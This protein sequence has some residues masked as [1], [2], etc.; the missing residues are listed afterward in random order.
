MKWEPDSIAEFP[1]AGT[2]RGMPSFLSAV[3]RGLRNRCPVCGEGPVFKGYLGLVPECAHCGTPLGR[4]RADD[5]PP[6]FTILLV[7]HLLVPGVLWVE[8]TWQPAM[9]LHMAVWLPLFTILCTL[10]LRPVKGAV[11]GWMVTLG[12]TGEEHGPAPVPV[13]RPASLDG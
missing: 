1:Q 2:S 8:K 6:Y 13:S 3:G 12:F 10:A 7:G 4:L 5:A 9:W 11:V